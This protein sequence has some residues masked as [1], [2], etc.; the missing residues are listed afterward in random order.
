[1]DG[2][3]YFD[4]ECNMEAGLSMIPGI[5]VR[6]PWKLLKWQARYINNFPL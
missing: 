1:M 6:C 5:R 2:V 4:G 3:G